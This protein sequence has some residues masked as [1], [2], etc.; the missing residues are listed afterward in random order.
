MIYFV[1][2]FF[3]RQPFIL[4]A[5]LEVFHSSSFIRGID[6][7]PQSRCSPLL[8]SKD[9]ARKSDCINGKCPGVEKQLFLLLTEWAD[10]V[11]AGQIRCFSTLK[12]GTS[13]FQSL[14]EAPCNVISVSLSL[15]ILSRR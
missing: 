6:S 11:K 8:F 13:T 5:L 12:S 4:L 2:W 9:A 10:G 1:I 7:L 3:H 14:A 15:F